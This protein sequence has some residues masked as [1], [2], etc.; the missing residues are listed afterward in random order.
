M[1]GVGHGPGRDCYSFR[2]ITIAGR[3][4]LLVDASRP[5]QL[6]EIKFDS[7]NGVT[8]VMMNIKIVKL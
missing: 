3:T 2:A 4:I 7:Y 8:P 5:V 6:C 1:W